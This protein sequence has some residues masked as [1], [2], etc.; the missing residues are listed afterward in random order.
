M[1]SQLGIDIDIDIDIDKL[2]VATSDGFWQDS[3]P[4]TPESLRTL[5]DNVAALEP[6]R[7][8]FAKAIGQL[9]KT[10]AIDARV[11]AQLALVA[12]DWM[13][14]WEPLN[15]Q[16]DDLLR[17]EETL[18]EASEVLETTDGVGRTTAV[19]LLTTLPEL[20][21]VPLHAQAA[22]PPE[23]E[24]AP[25][26]PVAGG[27]GAGGLTQPPRRSSIRS[28]RRS[29]WA[30]SSHPG[31]SAI[32]ITARAS[33]ADPRAISKWLPWARPRRRQPSAMFRT[34]D[35]E[36]RIPWFLRSER[37]RGKRCFTIHRATSRERR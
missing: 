13:P 33:A 3:S 21:R 35:A 9:V 12:V 8:S 16:I 36:A 6:H 26:P 30:C 25:A 11:L 34:T 29:F 4:Q 10:N 22:D 14:L 17:Q 7:R 2:D 23:R 37:P 15:S 20:G 28:T 31:R 5:A 24:D 32:I 18:T 19:T 1:A 27:A